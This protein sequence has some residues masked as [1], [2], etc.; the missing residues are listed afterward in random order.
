MGVKLLIKAPGWRTGGW[1][2]ELV[3]SKANEEEL[4]AIIC[5]LAFMHCGVCVQ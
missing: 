2:L 1:Y 4:D 3:I 5:A